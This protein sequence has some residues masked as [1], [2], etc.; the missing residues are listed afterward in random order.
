MALPDVRQR[1]IKLSNEAIGAYDQLTV[2]GRLLRKTLLPFWSWQEVNVG[3]EIRLWRNVFSS[4]EV[5]AALARNLGVKGVQATR[6]VAQVLGGALTVT[7]ATTLWNQTKFPEE[8]EKLPGYV[9]RRPHIITGVEPNGVIRYI[10]R[11]GGISDVLEWAGLND[12]PSEIKAYLNGEVPLVEL[13]SDTASAPVQKVLDLIT[14]TIKSP[15]EAAFGRTLYPDWRRPRR[16]PSRLEYMASSFSARPE[17]QL[18]RTG[19]FKKYAEEAYRSVTGVARAYP[20]TEAEI[21]AGE[22]GRGKV[23]EAGLGAET[24]R[25][26]SLRYDLTDKLR[27][28][29]KDK[30]DVPTVARDVL[31]KA[32]A[33][34]LTDKQMNRILDDALMQ[35]LE[36][37]VKGMTADEALRVYARAN[38]DE[39][40][41]LTSLVVGKIARADVTDDERDDLIERFR[42]TWK[43][44]AH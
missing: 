18:L 22:I 37:S 12:A 41:L 39:K 38:P 34:G 23:A 42:K 2:T 6:R 20:A 24:R 4:E 44:S 19:G 3:R 8:E 21:L 43:K 10:G 27:A 11:L 40:K 31:Q 29:I 7:A 32:K 26:S 17:A 35:P 5:G 13:L 1:A 33:G 9:K 16:I 36:A 14:P 25:K 30:K 28:A 15:M